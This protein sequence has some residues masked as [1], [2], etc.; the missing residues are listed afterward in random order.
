MK[1]SSR[2]A[3]RFVLLAGGAFS[4]MVGCEFAYGQSLD[5]LSK[6]DQAG[7]K[8]W[9]KTPFAV[10]NALFI[11]G[12]PQGFGAYTP[13]SPGPFKAGEHMIVYAEPVAYGWKSVEDDQYEFG[14]TA[15]LILKT[16]A[17]ER[18]IE[19]NN[20]GNIVFKSRAQNRE[21][22]VKLNVN[23]TGVD[24]GDYLLDIRLHDAEAAEKTGMIELPITLE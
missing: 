2:A 18:I 17:G 16:A 13:R 21:M 15:D 5:A 19:K 6:S 20:F 11:T 23:L 22:F 7:R 24:P 8:V 12:E 4:L 10:R 9:E 1:I 3:L 14:V